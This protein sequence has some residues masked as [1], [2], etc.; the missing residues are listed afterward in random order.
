M[1]RSAMKDSNPTSSTTADR[2]EWIIRLRFDATE[3]E[4]RQILAVVTEAIGKHGTIA[5]LARD[6]T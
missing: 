6:D 1:A 5:S 3:A 4:A 2:G